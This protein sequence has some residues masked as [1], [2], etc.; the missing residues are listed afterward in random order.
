MWETGN[1]IFISLVTGNKTQF[2]N[3]ICLFNVELNLFKVTFYLQTFCSFGYG[4]CLHNL[5]C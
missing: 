5:K 2:M 3:A 4:G 1:N